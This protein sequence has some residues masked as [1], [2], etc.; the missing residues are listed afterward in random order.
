M[1]EAYQGS[2]PG[3]G[4]YTVIQLAGALT[5]SS[6]VSPSMSTSPPVR[7]DSSS[8]PAREDSSTSS[9]S[10]TTVSSIS[11]TALSGE[12]RRARLVH[13][14][15]PFDFLL[16]CACSLGS[17]S[18]C[19]SSSSDDGDRARFPF[20]FEPLLLDSRERD[21]L[22]GGI[23]TAFSVGRRTRSDLRDIAEASRLEGRLWPE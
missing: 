20:D 14:C 12:D 4:Q 23:A 8:P 9:I 18:D 2:P 5:S 16:V 13:C 11:T 6:S 3:C 19:D 15:L 7:E 17:L 21:P 1:V 22:L 10:S